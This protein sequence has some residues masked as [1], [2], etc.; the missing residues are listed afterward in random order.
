MNAPVAATAALLTY[1]KLSERPASAVCRHR[2]RTSPPDDH[3]SD[4]AAQTDTV[5]IAGWLSK[6]R[7]AA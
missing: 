6:V 1:S 4:L 5:H 7:T 2:P 3:D